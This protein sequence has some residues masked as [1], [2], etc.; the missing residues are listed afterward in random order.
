METSENKKRPHRSAYSQIVFI[1]VSSLVCVSAGMALGHSAVLLPELQSSNSSIVVD[2]ETGSW[3][4]SVYSFTTPIGSLFGGVAMDVWGRKRTGIIFTLKMV[5][6]WTVIVGSQDITM[7]LVARIIEGFSRGAALTIFS[8]YGDELVSPKLRGT[9]LTGNAFFVSLGIMVI[10]IL[11]A[12]VDWRTGSGIGVGLSAI[13]F[14]LTALLPESPVWL[15]RKNRMTAAERSLQ[16]LCGPGRD[17][18]AK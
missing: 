5:L 12:V 7:L 13:S 17:L 6:G 16:W 14:F 8:V 10:S 11:S 3:I 4:A 15:V 2:E 9:V 18:E 1:A